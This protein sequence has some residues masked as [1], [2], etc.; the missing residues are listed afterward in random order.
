MTKARF[1]IKATVYDK[2]GRVLTVGENS[3]NKT[4]PLQAKYAAMVGLEDKIYLHAELS[5]LARLRPYHKPYRIKVERYGKDGKPALARPCAV[6]DKAIRE[7]G[8]NQV[9]YTE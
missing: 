8:I 7:W 3:Y 1:Q 4:H 9:E 2:R 5:A 6:C